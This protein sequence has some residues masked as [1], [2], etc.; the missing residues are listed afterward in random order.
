MILWVAKVC[1]YD[2]SGRSVL[3]A[4][5]NFEGR[6]PAPGDTIRVGMVDLQQEDQWIELGTSLAWR[7][8]QGCMLQFIPGLDSNGDSGRLGVDTLL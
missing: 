2:P 7:W 5:V 8:Q 6:F 3:G 1:I 4:Q